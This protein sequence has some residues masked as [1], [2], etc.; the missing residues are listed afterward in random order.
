MTQWKNVPAWSDVVAGWQSAMG[1]KGWETGRFT[2]TIDVIADNLTDL[3]S[4]S[5]VG[6]IWL[7]PNQVAL[8][9]PIT[10]A[11]LRAMATAMGPGNT[12][13]NQLAEL[14]A[15]TGGD[16][17]L[18]AA[19]MIHATATAYPQFPTALTLIGKLALARLE[20]AGLR[21]PQYKQRPTFL[22]KDRIDSMVLDMGDVIDCLAHEHDR[23]FERLIPVRVRHMLKAPTGSRMAAREEMA[24]S[25]MMEMKAT[26]GK[27][28]PAATDLNLPGANGK[29]PTIGL[30]CVALPERVFIRDAIARALGDA[31]KKIDALIHMTAEMRL[32]DMFGPALTASV[33]SAIGEGWTIEIARSNLLT[34][35]PEPADSVT[36]EVLDDGTIP[37]PQIAKLCNLI[38]RVLEYDE[39]AAT[40][41]D[42]IQEWELV[43]PQE[44]SMNRLTARLLELESIDVLGDIHWRLN[45]D[46]VQNPE[47][48]SIYPVK[49]LG[50]RV[51]N[52]RA[53]I[54]R[55]RLACPN[56]GGLVI[57]DDGISCTI[58]TPRSIADDALDQ[59]LYAVLGTP[60]LAQLENCFVDAI[61]TD[62][63]G[64]TI[65]HVR[66]RAYPLT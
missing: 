18:V 28:F 56:N 15:R 3:R 17:E 59:P 44:V 25:V 33:R 54:L 45:P 14:L 38:D 5:S 16:T 47:P 55:A 50:L 58:T 52:K 2:S 4:V 1:N 35:V 8:S 30:R 29:I 31:G 43:D 13:S 9:A 66:A 61:G 57:N 51:T 48:V 11:E 64:N 23:I 32:R 26:T 42:S 12:A 21:P 20:A 37:A 7:E 63:D 60:E 41:V 62:H 24:T 19:A 65:I 6:G 40:R 36:V 34:I 53:H 49:A 10:P 46:N 22:L 39:R 27:D